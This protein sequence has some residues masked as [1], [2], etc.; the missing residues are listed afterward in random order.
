M[1][2]T[3]RMIA[4][5]TL[6]L[7]VVLLV[8]STLCTGQAT[9]TKY[10]SGTDKDHTVA[11]DFYCTSGMNSKK[12]SKI[13]VPSCWELQGFGSYH[14]GWEEN[15]KE[16]ETGYYKFSF[17]AEAAWK[18]N[19]VKIVFEG[20]MTDTEVKINGQHAG[21]KHQG[22]FYK[23]S[24]DITRL[25]KDK[26]LLEVKVDKI[27]ADTSVNR[28][29][30]MSDFWVFGGI[31]RPVYL[32]ILP[33]QY[34]DHIAVD[35]GADGTLQLDVSVAAIK[36]ATTLEAQVT[37][38]DGKTVGKPF[39]VA[40]GTNDE[41]VHLA[42][43]IDSPREWTP[44]A[45][46]RYAIVVNL[47]NR[48]GVVH[49]VT[50][51]F[52]FRTVE[53][54]A[55]NGFFV[56]GK[57][58]ILKGVNRHTF[59]PTSGRTTSK[60]ISV[61]DINLIKDMNMNAVRMSHYPPETHFL[62]ACDSLGLFVMDELTGW[63]KKYDTPVGKKLVRE[64]IMKDV[65]HPCIIMWSNGNEGGNN[66]D[67]VNE[68]ARYD[69]QN[70]KVIH[71]W[72]IFQGTDT[73]HYK[74]Y[75]CCVGSL[76]HGTNVFFPT[77]FLHG[78]HD[79]GAGAG[80][81]DHWKLNEQNP[82]YA[83]GFLWAFADE[84]IMR[85]DKDSI[86]DS[87]DNR[88][89][90]GIV[91]PFREKEGSFFTIKEIWSPVQ[92]KEQTLLHGFTG[93]LTVENK[94][95]YTNL[96]DIRFEYRLATI[97]NY[98]STTSGIITVDK[99]AFTG[100]SLSPDERGI[101]H[102]PATTSYARADILYLSAFDRTGREIY[103]WS[104]PLKNIAGM[105]EQYLSDQAVEP[106]H[107]QS[108]KGTLTLSANGVSVT[109]DTSTGMIASVKHNGAIIS[110][111][112][113]P[114][115]AE[116]GG[117]VTSFRQ[118]D[119]GGEHVVEFVKSDEWRY[120]KYTMQRNGI[121]KIDY[122]YSL[123][124]MKGNKEF[125][126]M[127]INFSYPEEKIRGVRYAGRGPYRV[128]KNR[129]KGNAYGVWDKKYNNAITGERWDYPEFKGYYRNLQWVVVDSNEQPFAIFTTSDNLFLRLYTPAKPIGATN[130]NTTPRFPS[131]DISIL[132]AI[133]AIGTKFDLP[134][135]HGPQGEK[136][137]IG[138]ETISGTIFFDFTF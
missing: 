20:S 119:A 116:G 113:G 83:G 17:P 126:F 47:K 10:L 138:W 45:P 32:E 51:K 110:L 3:K 16:N 105:N 131:G 19:V 92:I 22:S 87:K 123:Y 97:P 84:G 88:G 132:H 23:F 8:N 75:D 65:N 4:R 64:M 81:E 49:T 121:L 76:N 77:E 29:E 101:L 54:R 107:A 48:K 33:A 136:N 79:G 63:Q 114:S 60:E 46:N 11:W 57:K 72:N 94:F 14:Y 133:N 5:I 56:N 91:G 122:G 89:P 52:G 124:N 1:A 118:Y 38:L 117:T 43:K 55:G 80:L 112:N 102:I 69:P 27:S 106:V 12:W 103:T 129:M 134:A 2:K 67:L 41:K 13:N 34:I 95:L 78:L 109:I 90:D 99:G 68:Y 125:E 18:G 128:W 82:L 39:S 70:R 15:V 7:F 85:L 50:E 40:F 59:W 73:Q 44:E 61:L 62:D 42:T 53:F 130:D 98:K 108:E 30:R 31:H 120:L 100:P 35:A 86:I 28:A 26:N 6:F 71:P 58:I 21:A 137:K 135:Y 96:H 93:D 37:T 111:T 36:D 74:G 115:L 25:L 104:W 9:I 24:Y 127:G 66:H